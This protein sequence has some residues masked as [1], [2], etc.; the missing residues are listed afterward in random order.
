M[1]EQWAMVLEM[2]WMF[3]FTGGGRN[4]AGESSI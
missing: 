1:P 3:S 4:A 2:E